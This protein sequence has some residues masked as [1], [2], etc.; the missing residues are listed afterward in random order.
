MQPESAPADW[1]KLERIRYLLDSWDL[2]FDPNT[3]SPLGLPGDGS[4]VALLPLMSRH[5]SVV[6]LDR[7]LNL[8]LHAAPGEY[9]HLKAFR[10]GCEYRTVTQLQRRRRPNGKHEI[11]PVRVRAKVLPRWIRMERVQAGELFLEAKFRGEV[12][13]PRELWDALNTPAV[14]A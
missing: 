10:V 4:G 9:R 13:I 11:V 8:L 5:H 6:E 3:T 7:V 14:A 2:I 1:S 12:D